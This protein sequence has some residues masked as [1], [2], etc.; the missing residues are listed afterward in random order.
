MTNRTIVAVAGFVVAS[1]TIQLA[2][3]TVSRL[4][5]AGGLFQ[6]LYEGS[7]DPTSVTHEDLLAAQRELRSAGTADAVVAVKWVSGCLRRPETTVKL[8]AIAG[9]Y[10]ISERDDSAELLSGHIKELI[11]LF[12]ESDHRLQAGPAWIFANLKPSIPKDA[13]E[14]LI[15]FVKRTDRD[16]SAQAV[17]VSALLKSAS[18]SS[19]IVPSVQEF[20]DRP[21]SLQTRVQVVNAIANSH[22]S[23]PRLNDI[24]ATSAEQGDPAIR[25]AAVQALLRMDPEA[26]RQALP[27]LRRLA[28]SPVMPDGDDSARR[29][30]SQ[31]RGFAR[32]VLDRVNAGKR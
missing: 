10:S 30:E 11:T 25:L 13:I 2:G 18:L 3:Q 12:D 7:I 21:I 26:I 20:W 9:L 4:S 15:V 24:I 22:V 28:E 31:I 16:D 19:D 1:L 29:V 8:F 14:Q 32:Q 27:A 5:A 17:A 23:S 6:D